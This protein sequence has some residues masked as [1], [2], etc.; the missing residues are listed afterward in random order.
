MALSSALPNPP[1]WIIKNQILKPKDTLG[2]GLAK[3]LPRCMSTQMLAWPPCTG[4][5]CAL[6]LYL[7]KTVKEQIIRSNDELEK[8]K[9]GLRLSKDSLIKT[10]GSVPYLTSL[11]E[12][13]M[14][15][16]V[17]TDETIVSCFHDMIFYRKTPNLSHKEFISSI[18]SPHKIIVSKTLSKM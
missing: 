8:A 18:I 2:S 7:L 15:S 14:S 1:E 6:Q 4:K 16:E 13:Y 17:G 11:P 12:G 5:S 3:K 9:L 10:M